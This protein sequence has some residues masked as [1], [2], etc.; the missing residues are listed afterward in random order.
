MYL[1]D[2]LQD[3]RV[4]YNQ[5]HY[6]KVFNDPESVQQLKDSIESPS[7]FALVEVCKQLEDLYCF[8]KKY[9]Y[10]LKSSN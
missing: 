9:Y 6:M 7:L 5:Q 4:K 8:N 3:N 1:I 2:N 10:K